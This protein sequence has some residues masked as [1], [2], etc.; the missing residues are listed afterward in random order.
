MTGALGELDDHPVGESGGSVEP[1]ADSG[2]AEGQLRQPRH[3][4]SNTL[5]AVSDLLGIARELLPE[6]DGHRIL[7]M[8]AP[9]LDHVVE[10]ASL[11][12]EGLGQ[13]GERRLQIFG[14]RPIGRQV[15]GRRDDV[16]R[17]LTG[18]DVVVGMDRC[19][20]AHLATQQLDGAVGDDLVG[21]HVGGGPRAGLEDVE[22]KMIVVGPPSHLSRRLTDGIGK[23]LVEH[24]ARR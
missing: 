1:G 23:L 3:G 15:N 17:G 12:L 18:V 16:V 14:H 10:L 13:M 4:R 2:T 11:R 6:P 21:V 20:R 22:R 9:D 19:L 24:P 5:L 8:G 7:E